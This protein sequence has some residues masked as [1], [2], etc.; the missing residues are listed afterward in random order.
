VVGSVFVLY[1]IFPTGKL[2]VLWQVLWLVGG[3]FTQFNQEKVI[4]AKN[5]FILFIKK[6]QY[7]CYYMST[8]FYRPQRILILSNTLPLHRQKYTGGVPL[9][10]V[11]SEISDCN[12]KCTRQVGGE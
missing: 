1:S 11:I 7:S 9:Y 8:N 6:M 5:P 2:L 4:L 3:K 12:A 10:H